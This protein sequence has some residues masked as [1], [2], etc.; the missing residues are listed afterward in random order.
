M[1]ACAR[2]RARL[3]S[4]CTVAFE[5]TCAWLVQLR[6]LVHAGYPRSEHY[7]WLSPGPRDVVARLQLAKTIIGFRGLIRNRSE[8]TNTYLRLLTRRTYG[9]RALTCSSPWP[10][11]PMAASAN[12]PGR[13]RQSTHKNLG[14]VEHLPALLNVNSGS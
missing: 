9:Y 11:S 12:I 6:M 13:S 7:C 8:A 10:T 3:R 14:R 4:R 2:G 5:D 1:A